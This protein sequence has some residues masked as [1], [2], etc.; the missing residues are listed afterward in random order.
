MKITA[1]IAALILALGVSIVP[2][3]SFGGEVQNF[4]DLS[5]GYAWAKDA[6]DICQKADAISGYPDG[7]F[8]PGNEISGAE[9]VKV[10]VSLAGSPEELECTAVSE[11]ESH[12]GARYMNYAKEKLILPEGLIEEGK[13]D[14]ALTRQQM[15]VILENITEYT[16]LK[17]ENIQDE[18]KIQQVQNGYKDFNQVGSGYK[19]KIIQA[20]LKGLI[21]GYPDG[22]FGPQKKATRAEASVMLSRLITGSSTV[23]TQSSGAL[24]D[25]ALLHPVQEAPKPATN[26]TPAPA[27]NVSGPVGKIVVHNISN[28]CDVYNT[29]G[30]L[31]KN[32][33]VSTG[34]PG[35]ET[36]LGTY[37]I[38]EHTT[39]KGYHLMVDGSYG[40]WCMRFK[41]GGYMFHSVCY[42]KSGAAYPIAQ[43][44][45]DLGKSVSRGCVRLAVS[46][47]EWLYKNTPYGAA[48]CIVND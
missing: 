35:H 22:T 14:Q 18:E 39:G 7:S 43:E 48:V 29:A 13:W 23:S 47:A 21:G 24:V 20:S 32:F 8:R 34:R 16:K 11:G 42:A 12:W 26:P 45:A 4:S 10:A 40:R 25:D 15:A 3:T 27:A 28:K 1:R 36:P 44:V 30:Q 38:Y 31:M 46:D 2:V 6:I 37:Q 33:V 17:K 5:G 41:T 19:D 9:F